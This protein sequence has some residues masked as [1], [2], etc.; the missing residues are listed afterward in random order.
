MPWPDELAVYPPLLLITVLLARLLPLPAA[1]HPLTAFR[2]FAR[3]LGKKVNPDP[4]RARA[5]QY[6][7]GSLALLVAWLP[8]MALLYSLYRFSELPLVLDALLLFCSLDWQSRRYQAQQVSQ[9]LQQNQLT[10]A[11]EQAQPLLLRNCSNLTAMG[12]SKAVIENLLLQSAKQLIGTGCFFLLGG[13]LAAIGYRLVVQLQ[14]EWNPKQAGYQLFGRPTAV[15]AKLLSTL[16]MLLS[17]AFIAMQH[18]VLRFYRNSKTTRYRFNPAAFYLLCAGSAALH[19][20]LGGPV[21]YHNTKY[22]R[23]RIAGQRPPGAA[24]IN[25]CLRLLGFL[26]F[27]LLLLV[28]SVTLLQLAWW[29][30]N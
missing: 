13:G 14:Q 9:S 30:A 26:H 19:C 16:P 17:S 8:A 10:L 29:L 6:I 2:Y 24:D 20:D 25:S 27:Y 5:Q 18:G 3:S 15:I 7:S 22:S 21:Y 12:L 23:S 4:G 11:R 1:Y 28:S